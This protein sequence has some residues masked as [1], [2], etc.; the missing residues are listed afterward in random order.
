VKERIQRAGSTMTGTNNMIEDI[1]DSE[2]DLGKIKKINFMS[3]TTYP[4]NKGSIKTQ[5]KLG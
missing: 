1:E 5:P 3:L 4:T 2:D